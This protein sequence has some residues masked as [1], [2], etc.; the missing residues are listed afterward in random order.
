M[1]SDFLEQNLE[2]IVYENQKECVKRGFPEFYENV[3]R[4]VR[5]P[6]GKIMDI[7][8]FEIRNEI[9]FCK[10]FELKKE[11]ISL[12]TIFQVVNYGYDLYASVGKYSKDAQIE[13]YCVGNELA[14]EILY[15]LAW[16]IN[17]TM[18]TYSYN[19]DGIGFEVFKK[20]GFP[21]SEMRTPTF[22][23]E[24]EKFF[25]GLFEKDFRLIN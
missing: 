21:Y 23:E 2:T 13:L 3:K 9:M 16:G 24:N 15:L 18:V 11:E 6:T 20:N 14:G 1:P 12:N 8:S 10:I 4:Q 19:V 17:I 7:F 25:K 5:L 22:S